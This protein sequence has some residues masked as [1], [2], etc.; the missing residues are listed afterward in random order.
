MVKFAWVMLACVVQSF[1]IAP[2]MADEEMAPEGSVW[3]GTFKR[4]GRKDDEGRRIS[5]TDARLKIVERKDSKFKAELWL[6]RA[7][8]GLALEGTI[9]PTGVMHGTP[10]KVLKGDFASDIVG[11]AQGSGRIGMGIMRMQYTIP[12][13]IRF[14]EMELKEKE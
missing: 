7:A 6:D 2:C 4:F 9:S 8:K 10:M 5:S 3:V 12:N 13:G 14:G 11:R 1:I